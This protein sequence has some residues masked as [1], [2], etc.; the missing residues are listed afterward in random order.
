[1]AK[2]LLGPEEIPFELFSKILYEGMMTY[3]TLIANHM[4]V[5]CE[6]YNKFL[7]T[8]N[9]KIRSSNDI[10]FS[11]HSPDPKLT[12]ARINGE[13]PEEFEERIEKLSEKYDVI[14]PEYTG[15][16]SR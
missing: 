8:N 11:M 9:V 10:L 12:I 1:M 14:I 7:G 3:D 4:M 13:E 15:L 6:G 2:L 5:A 16:L